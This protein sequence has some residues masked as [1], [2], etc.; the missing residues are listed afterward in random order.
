MSVR[1]AADHRF[2]PGLSITVTISDAGGAE[3]A[4]GPVPFLWHPW[5][6]HYGANFSLPGDGLYTIDV[7]V[8]PPT[9]GRHDKE[10]GKR[11]AEPV[12][13]T[14]ADFSITTDKA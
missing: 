5:L 13:V 4:S 6:Y 1:D 2:I 10:N 9:F 11:Y 3:V 14:F 7:A 12:S 8:D